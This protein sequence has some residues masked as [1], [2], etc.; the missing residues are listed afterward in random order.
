M[1]LK[2]YLLLAVL[3]ALPVFFVACSDDDDDN[4][5]GVMRNH[6]TY[7]GSTFDLDHGLMLSGG[8]W[9]G[10]GYIFDV[11]LYSDG[12]EFTDD[13]M[14]AT[15]EGHGMFFE[16]YSPDEADLA[17]GRYVYDP[18]DEGDPFT[19]Y[20]ADIIMDWDS[21]TDE[22]TEVAIVGGS[23]EVDRSGSTYT[24]QIDATGEDGQE[25][26]GYFRGPIPVFDFDDFWMS[27]EKPGLLP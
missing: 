25:I 19:F 4:G 20:L 27:K 3:F 5:N 11:F 14:D 10:D 1:K 15:G 9:W 23:V 7:D 18:D 6:F 2:K 21:E 17:P 16:M 8:Q 12:I 24:L 22:G 13:F 26:T